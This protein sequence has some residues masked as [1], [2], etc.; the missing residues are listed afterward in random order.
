MEP[1]C[2]SW[3][4]REVEAMRLSIVIVTYSNYQHKKHESK[5]FGVLDI[6][7]VNLDPTGK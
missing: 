2:Q 4:S 3:G 5:G 7:A 1:H 6:S